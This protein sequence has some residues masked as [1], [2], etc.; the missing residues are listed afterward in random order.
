MSAYME[1]SSVDTG[2]HAG[3]AL[4]SRTLI[5]TGLLYLLDLDGLSRPMEQVKVAAAV[6]AAS[7][8]SQKWVEG[9]IM[10]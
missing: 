3:M 10:Q 7:L 6:S 8:A 9:M 4:I 1:G 2:Y 5:G